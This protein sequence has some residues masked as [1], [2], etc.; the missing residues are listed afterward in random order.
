MTEN[1]RFDRWSVWEKK[2]W[3]VPHTQ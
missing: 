3:A 1:F 2:W